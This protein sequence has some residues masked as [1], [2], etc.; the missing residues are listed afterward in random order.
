MSSFFERGRPEQGRFKELLLVEAMRE[1]SC[2]VKA[3]EVEEEI[4]LAVLREAGRRPYRWA[5]C[6]DFDAIAEA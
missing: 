3:R 1:D 2:D 6:F 4:S 5:S